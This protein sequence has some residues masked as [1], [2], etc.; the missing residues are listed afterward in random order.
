MPISACTSI[1]TTTIVGFVPGSGDTSGSVVTFTAPKPV[2]TDTSGRT[3]LQC[4]AV[5]IGG[6]NGLN[7]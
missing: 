4:N 1:Y 7:S 5:A 6:F 3:D 2:W